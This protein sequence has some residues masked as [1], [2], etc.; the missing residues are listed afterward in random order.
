VTKFLLRLALCTAAL[1]AVTSTV[2]NAADFEPPPPPAE[3]WTG[4]YIGAFLTGVGVESHY[5][6]E[7]NNPADCQFDPE[8]SGFTWGGG[9]LAGFNFEVSPGFLLGVEGDWGW[10]GKIDNDDPNEATELKIND[11]ATLR[12]RAGVIFNEDTLFYATAGAAWVKSTFGGEVGD[13]ANPNRP[14]IDDTQWTSGYAVGGGIEHAFNHYLHA[15]ME[16][17]YIG[18]P[19]EKY[20][21]E[22]G[23][24][25][26]NFEGIHLI[27]AAMTVDFGNFF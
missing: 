21:L 26:L 25:D 1:A 3:S 7:C 9:L 23:T 13:P 12:G 2:A 18:L 4:P 22:V 8:M 5:D 24:V 16:Y 10:A 15:R 27:R 20:D 14:F 19:D 11:I 17:I 6:S